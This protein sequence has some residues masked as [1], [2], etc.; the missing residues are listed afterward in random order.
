LNFFNAIGIAL[1]YCVGCCGAP[2][3]RDLSATAQQSSVT[4]IGIPLMSPYQ[5]QQS[6]DTYGRLEGGNIQEGPA[7]GAAC[8]AATKEV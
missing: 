1:S 4:F 6:Y 3:G 7:E 2:S 8:P 5:A